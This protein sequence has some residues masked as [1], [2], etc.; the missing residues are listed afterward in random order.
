M[1]TTHWSDFLPMGGTPTGLLRDFPPVWHARLKAEPEDFQVTEDLALPELEQQVPD[2]QREHLWLWVEKRGANT[3]WVAG[4]L[5]GHFG[6]RRRDVGFSG[7]KDRHALTRQWF[8]VWLPGLH[9]SLN[10][11]YP[12]PPSHAEYRVLK[13]A[14][15]RRKLQRGTH[16]HN[17]F[18]IR[19]RDVSGEHAAIEARLESIRRQGV[20][21]FFGPQ[22]F[23]SGDTRPWQ[24]P[25][26]A[27]EWSRES[28][29]RGWQLSALRSA[30]FNR[31]LAMKTDAGNWRSVVAGDWLQ[32]RGTRAGFPAPVDLDDRLRGLLCSGELNPTTWLP[33]T[34]EQPECRA[35]DWENYA[36]APHSDWVYRLQQRRVRGD[37]RSNQLFVRAIEWQNQGRDWWLSFALPAGTF[38][39]AVLATL[40]PWE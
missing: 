40:G 12:E 14:W 39:T 17:H 32:W 16:R 25:S 15:Q 13:S 10:G 4:Q 20:P 31:A 18:Q 24:M 37:R 36:L 8:S 11:D 1:T 7:Q 22:R 30:L 3:A 21:N 23:G 9:R 2:G 26:D 28:A 27:F 34:G 33:G 29:E 6:R 19:L 38:A 35:T 5:A